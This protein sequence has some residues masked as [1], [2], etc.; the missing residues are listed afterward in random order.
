MSLAI[1]VYVPEGIIMASDS[2]QSLTVEG[3]KQTGEPF[4]FETVNSDTVYKTFLLEDQQIGISNFGADLLGKIPMSSH[5]KTFVEKAITSNDDVEAIPRKLL[6]YF[7]ESFA[8]ADVGFHVAGYKKEGELSVPYVYH[9]HVGKNDLMRRN[10]EDDG[11]LIYGAAWSGAIDVIA[12]IILP[13][14]A[15]TKGGADKVIRPVAPILWDA[16]TVQDAIDF[17]VYAIRTTIDTMRFQARPKT[18]GG[19]IDVLLL[20]PDDKPKWI[21]S[22]VIAVTT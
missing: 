1:V 9:C 11:S 5:I 3:K 12:S 4:K 15:K 7:Q 22:K 20:T 17:A 18:V 6:K 13:V 8:G 14:T 10:T 2:R 21:S 16:M 19:P